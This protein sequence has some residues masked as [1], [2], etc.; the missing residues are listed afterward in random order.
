MSKKI[1]IALLV[2]GVAAGGYWYKQKS[3]IESQSGNESSLLQRVPA[4]SALFFGGLETLPYVNPYDAETMKKMKSYLDD[5]VVEFQKITDDLNSPA[6]TVISNLYLQASQYFYSGNVTEMN[7]FAVYSLGVY[8]VIAWKSS[9]IATFTSELNSIEKDNNI[10]PRRFTL[11]KAEI[12]EYIIS[13]N[14]PV[15]MFITING[16]NVSLA[17]LSDNEAMQ[18]LLAGVDFP[19]QNL[20]NTNKL[21]NLKLK[22]KLLPY[23][24]SY[25]DFNAAMINLSSS[26]DN[27]LKQ[28]LL[29]VNK[30]KSLEDITQN[31]CFADAKK[32]IAKWPRIAF[33]YRH[34]DIN[35]NPIVMDAAM[36]IEHTDGKFL[37]SLSDLLGLLPDF[38]MDQDLYSLGLGIN[39]DHLASFLSGL[40][41]DV[42]NESY[43]CE[44]LVNMQAKM[45]ANDSSMIAMGTQMIAGVQGLSVHITKADVAAVTAGDMSQLEGMIVITANNPKNLLMAAGNFY[46]PISGMQI[47]ANGEAQPLVLPMGVSA[48]ISLSDNAVVLQFGEAEDVKN[49]I[50]AIHQGKGLSTALI[51]NGADLS[52]FFTMLEPMMSAGLAKAPAEDVEKMKNMITLFQNLKMKYVYDISIEEAGIAFNIKMTMNNAAK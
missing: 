44:G 9:N 39:V 35:S 5:Q 48:K 33:G 40:R 8:P 37:N 29:E 12:R 19:E 1:I 21:Q 26:E 23:A 32:I 2:A 16:N 24:M 7:D 49:R 42:M 31:A 47:E 28:S 43:Q 20:A 34:Y 22:H 50:A 27:L 25:F 30:G 46:P 15:K 36:I 11:G 18:K 45:A 4:D 10:S 14:A 6:A 41:K 17:A 38:S 13:K 3:P 51:R 52:A